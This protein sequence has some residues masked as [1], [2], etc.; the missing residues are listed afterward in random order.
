MY[1][2]LLKKLQHHVPL[3]VNQQ[4]QLVRCL[5]IEEIPKGSTLLEAGQIA[6]QLYFVNQGVL[7]LL[8]QVDDQEV[9]R[10][11]CFPNHFAVSYSSF[12]H[13]QPSQES[14]VTNTDSQIVSITYRSLNYLFQQ[15]SVWT[16]LSL[17][18]LGQYYNR[19]LKQH[20]YHQTQSAAER[21]RSLIRERPDI[22]DQVPLGQI[23]SFLGITQPTLSRLRAR[24]A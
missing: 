9:T 1:Q 16:T 19:L 2:K 21:Y 5:E 7:R 4:E 17:E 23:A 10:W 14:I 8:C 6:N 24:S 11:F 13:R 20:L 22:A 18:L 15:D 12:F 3:N